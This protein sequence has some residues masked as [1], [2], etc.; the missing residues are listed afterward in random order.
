MAGA[1]QLDHQGDGG[2]SGA[3]L[4]AGAEQLDHHGD[5]G[6]PERRPGVVQRPARGDS[7]YCARR[8]GK[9]M[10]RGSPPLYPLFSIR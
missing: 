8:R 6:G 4:L 2:R 3:A 7:L 9:T 1:E 5:G 10:S